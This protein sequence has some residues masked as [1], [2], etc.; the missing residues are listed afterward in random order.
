MKD[1]HYQ[2]EWSAYAENGGVVCRV[3]CSRD[4]PEGTK[5]TY[6]QDLIREDSERV[7]EL[8]GEKGAWVFISG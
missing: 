3:A 5:R 4:G 7:W 8:V 6:V 2:A 1:Q